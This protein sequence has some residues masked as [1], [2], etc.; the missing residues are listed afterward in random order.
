MKKLNLNEYGVQELSVEESR[1]IDGGGTSNTT[2]DFW[3]WVKKNA[4]NVGAFLSTTFIAA[5]V[6]WKT[7]QQ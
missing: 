2:G 1:M 6:L 4:I 5:Y 7:N 3:T